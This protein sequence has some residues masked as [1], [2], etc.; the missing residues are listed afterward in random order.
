MVD[1]GVEEGM[2]DY[3]DFFLVIVGKSVIIKER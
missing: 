2:M 1:E 3:C